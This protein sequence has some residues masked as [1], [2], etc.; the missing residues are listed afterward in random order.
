MPTAALRG[1]RSVGLHL[2]MGCTCSLL[3]SPDVSSPPAPPHV[4]ERA[5]AV[6]KLLNA[7][8]V[9]QDGLQSIDKPLI[10]GPDEHIKA[11]YAKAIPKRLDTKIF[12]SEERPIDDRLKSSVIDWRQA[13]VKGSSVTGRRL[14]DAIRDNPVKLKKL[15]QKRMKQLSPSTYTGLASTLAKDVTKY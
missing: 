2:P 14:Q 10:Q 1:L 11:E 6:W 9:G 15:S 5:E 4:D 12:R 7:I 13:E 3:A 8:F